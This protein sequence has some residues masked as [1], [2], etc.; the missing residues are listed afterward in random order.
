MIGELVGTVGQPVVIK[1][2]AQDFGKAIEAVQFSCDEGVTWTSY[3]TH[4]ADPDRN[5]NWS[6]AFTP[7]QTGRYR[8]LV[9]AL[10]SDGGTTPEP[11]CINIEARGMVSSI[12]GYA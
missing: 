11:A 8:V 9:R 2:Y 10:R 5:V 3:E 1:G 4:D 7:P 12:S 6:F